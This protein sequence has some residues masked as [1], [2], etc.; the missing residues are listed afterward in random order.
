M[1]GDVA[2][3]CVCEEAGYLHSPIDYRCERAHLR[4]PSLKL[5]L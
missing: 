4:Q 5:R 2:T 1:R 3:E